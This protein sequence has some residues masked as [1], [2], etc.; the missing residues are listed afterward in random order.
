MP[1]TVCAGALCA[2]VGACVDPQLITSNI[3]VFNQ[4]QQF[5]MP[6]VVV[7]Q[8]RIDSMRT[9]HT[10]ERLCTAVTMSRM[11]AWRTVVGLSSTTKKWLISGWRERQDPM[12]SALI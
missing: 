6:V 2:A 5:R 4:L 11:F 9:S 8:T 3:C 7:V 10:R 1:Q 12:Y